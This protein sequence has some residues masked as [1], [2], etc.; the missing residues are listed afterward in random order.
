MIIW[1]T[2]GSRLSFRQ[3]I[4][5]DYIKYGKENAIETKINSN[6]LLYLKIIYLY[7]QGTS[8]SKSSPQGAHGKTSNLTGSE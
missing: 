3:Y 6:C 1:T 8:K 2:N 7:L 5:V 4:T